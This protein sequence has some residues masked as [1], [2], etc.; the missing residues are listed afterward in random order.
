MLDFCPILGRVAGGKIKLYLTG[1]CVHIFDTFHPEICTG[2][3]YILICTNPFI[4]QMLPASVFL[5]GKVIQY[6]PLSTHKKQNFI[7]YC[8]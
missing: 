5:F 8:S 1:F 3:H 2:K 7:C 6:L 4:L